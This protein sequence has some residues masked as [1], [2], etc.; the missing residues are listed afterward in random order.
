MVEPARAPPPSPGAV[1]LVRHGEPALSRR[2]R[3]TARE[4][5]D[6][7]ATYEAG[8]LKVGQAPPCELVAAAARAGALVCST[9]RRAVESADAIAP[10]GP[11]E[12]DPLFVEAPL[13]PPPLP[14]WIRL[15]PRWW[16]VISRIR[17][18]LF[19]QEAGEESFAEAS[20]RA[21]V[22][23]GR[24]IARAAGGDEV[25]VMAHGFFNLMVGRAL[26]ARGWRRTR[27]EGFRYWSARR[28]EPGG[29]GADSSAPS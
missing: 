16:G 7:W 8:G 11:W 1:T 3:L 22:A 19:A 24:L 12:V 5:R 21:R 2:V 17:W 9:R 29:A 23:A 25:L 28:F 20:E 10:G 18:W 27:N 15:P 4:Y 14:T 6:W 26:E 13:P